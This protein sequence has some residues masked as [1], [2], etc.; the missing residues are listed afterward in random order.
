[1]TSL[2]SATSAST[3]STTSS[4]A[5]TSNSGGLLQTMGVGSGLDITSM[6]NA[7]TDAEMA[8]AN[9]R[10]NREQEA[11]TTQVS[12]M[13]TLK[14]A[15]STFQ[16]SM[17]SML[18]T[19]GFN[20]RVATPDDSTIFTATAT[21]TAALGDYSVRV[22]NLATKSQLLWSPTTNY[23]SSSIMGTGNMTLSSSG[24]SFTVNVNST[25]NT[26]AGIRD[27]I[28]SASGNTSINATL[29][30]SDTGAQLML[31]S[32]GTGSA[33]AISVKVPSSSGSLSKLDSTSGNN[34]KVASVASDATI[35]IGGILSTSGGVTSVINAVTKTSSTNT[36]TDAIDG[37][38]LTLLSKSGT[39]KNTG[40]PT[41]NSFTV[42]NNSTDAVSQA[43]TQVKAFVDAYNTLQDSIGSLDSYDST[44]GDRGPFFSDS[45][46]STL[47]SQLGQALTN[48]VTGITS[49]YTSLA[50]LGITRGVD[51]KLSMDD[52][53]FKAALSADYLAASKVFSGSNGVMSRMNS[54]ITKTLLSN[55][56]V[57]SR[58]ATLRN[59]QTQIDQEKAMIAARTATIKQR[60]MTKFN[61]MDSLLATMQR[62][63]TFLT[64]QTD[65][66]N[67]QSKS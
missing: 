22:V 28:N 53:K 43:Q 13:A 65:A 5:T 16:G 48:K 54:V 36:I 15:L 17:T 29:V 37:V 9:A 51:G 38:T 3:T 10:V 32:L 39:N 8:A 40:A 14:S 62:T 11:V 52:T 18:S 49:N 46:Y 64:Q 2:T 25:N 47:K 50:A 61:A 42:A 41:L 55:G 63:A 56:M 66:L 4:A 12:A 27:A 57:S 20:T 23:T 33:S 24:N 7:L 60:Y 45:S 44:T 6:V 34:Y 26:L 1:M 19:T 21:S 67:R 35:Q 30:Y 58:N 59:R 31:N